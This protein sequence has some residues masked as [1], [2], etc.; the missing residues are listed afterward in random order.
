[1][2]PQAIHHPPLELEL[3]TPTCLEFQTG[4]AGCMAM[5][6][7]AAT[8]AAYLDTHHEWFADCARP[9]QV[10][11]LGNNGYI[12]TI[13]RFSAFGYEVEP[14]IAVVLESAAQE[15]YQMQTFPLEGN[16]SCGYEVDYRAVMKLLEVDADA[17]ESSLK[18]VCRSQDLSPPSIVTQVHWELNLNVVLDLPKFLAKLPKSLLQ[19]TGDR[20]L[21]QIV[22]QVSPRLTLRVQEDFHKRFN[23]P[24]PPKNGNKLVKIA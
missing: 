15:T 3:S 20:L 4:F 24:L 13:G 7:D 21:S 14:K 5:Y 16:Y 17:I 2:P 18:K 10:E 19:K 23:L 6:S 1:M 8:V 22:R 9:M 12:L 11:S